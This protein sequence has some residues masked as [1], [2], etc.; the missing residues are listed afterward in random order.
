[1]SNRDISMPYYSRSY[2]S[3][4]AKKDVKGVVRHVTRDMLFATTW[5]D[6]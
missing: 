4:V 1:M 2:L 6:H 3:T 5:P